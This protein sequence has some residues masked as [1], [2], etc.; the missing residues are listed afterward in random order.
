MA[1]DVE[2]ILRMLETEDK[3]EV[4]KPRQA[5]AK[6]SLLAAVNGDYDAI[7]ALL[8]EDISIDSKEFAEQM[9]PR[10]YKRSTAATEALRAKKAQAPAKESCGVKALRKRAQAPSKECDATSVTVENP[11]PSPV[12]KKNADEGVSK[13][14]RVKRG[15]AKEEISDDEWIE[16]ANSYDGPTEGWTDEKVREYFGDDA[17]YSS[18]D[19]ILMGDQ[20]WDGK[21]RRNGKVIGYF[22]TDDAKVKRGVAKEEIVSVSSNDSVF[23]EEIDFDEEAFAELFGLN[24]DE[25][26]V[27]YIPAEENEPEYIE[28]KFNEGGKDVLI[29][30]KDNGEVEEVVDAEIVEPSRF[31]ATIAPNEDGEYQLLISTAEEVEDKPKTE[32]DPDAEGV[33]EEGGQDAE[34][35][36]EPAGLDMDAEYADDHGMKPAKN[37]A[38]KIKEPTILPVNEERDDG[39]QA[40][41]AKQLRSFKRSGGKN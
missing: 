14:L 29:K 11:I 26:S 40:K 34:E 28:V 31:S 32:G 20:G 37:A 23:P 15:V 10:T 3:P 19:G 33:D 25:V 30:V 2:K 39:G 12:I 24:A 41:S 17:F 13:F 38:D 8:E 21:V 35:I 27:N 36:V 18:G 4:A 5:V 1:V 9:T 22:D 16:R 6:E 7:N